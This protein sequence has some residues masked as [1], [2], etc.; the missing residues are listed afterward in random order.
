MLSV[1]LVFAIYKL[2]LK[3][4]MFSYSISSS[5]PAYPEQSPPQRL[6][7]SPSNIFPSLSSPVFPTFAFQLVLYAYFYMP[8]S[9]AFMQSSDS[10][11][12]KESLITLHSNCSLKPSLPWSFFALFSLKK[13]VCTSEF[14][15]RHL[16]CFHSIHVHK[17]LLI[18][19][20]LLPGG[21]SL[22]AFCQM[23]L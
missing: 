13:T 4:P 23:Y 15:V 21:D 18:L 22:S 9:F 20:H 14:V 8:L 12:A 3:S 11:S 17:Q 10:S 1:I 5:F 2:C 6:Y 19:K 16:C 7:P